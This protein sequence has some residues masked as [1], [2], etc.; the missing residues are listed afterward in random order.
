MWVTLSKE[1][2]L[3]LKLIKFKI[4]KDEYVYGLGINFKKKVC[5]M[6]FVTI[7][8]RIYEIKVVYLDKP[9]NFLIFRTFPKRDLLFKENLWW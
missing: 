2:N 4:K 1:T 7:K 8:R 6:N 9:K 3:F 5:K